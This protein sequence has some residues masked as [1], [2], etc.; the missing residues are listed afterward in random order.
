MNRNNILKNSIVISVI[1]LFLG[2]GFQP[3]L[4]DEI[5]TTVVSDVDEDCLDCQPVNRV[6]LL[7]VKLL[8]TRLEVF[9]NILMSKF[10]HIPG[11]AD[12]CEE[13]SEGITT[14][15]ERINYLKLKLPSQEYIILCDILLVI[16]ISWTL[17]YLSVHYFAEIF[18]WKFPELYY[19]FIEFVDENIFYPIDDILNKLYVTFDC[20]FFH[21]P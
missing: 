5:S 20:D 12:E 17:L 16:V 21:F 14:L 7:R 18:Y 4:A 15:Q 2:V 6:E 11:I 3:A 19:R 13:V 1:L 8:L 10:G 9:T